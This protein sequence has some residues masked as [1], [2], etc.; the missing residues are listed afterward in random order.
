MFS[1]WY[2]LSVIS[3]RKKMKSDYERAEE[4]GITSKVRHELGARHH[5]MSWRIIEFLKEIDTHDDQG[6]FFWKSGEEGNNGERLMKQ[7]DSFFELMDYDSMNGIR[8]REK[9]IPKEVWDNP[10]K[11]IPEGN[12]CYIIDKSR[13]PPKEPDFSLPIIYCPF[14]DSNE[15]QLHQSNGYCHLLKLGDWMKEASGLL[16]DQL[17]ECTIN[18]LDEQD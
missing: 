12:Y 8:E 6:F 9:E 3:K 14:W 5:F 18:E 4:L 13:M 1:I 15:N 17:K 2:L 11:Y 10:D 16:W 7:L